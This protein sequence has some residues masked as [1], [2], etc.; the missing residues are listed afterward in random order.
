MVFFATEFITFF[1]ASQLNDVHKVAGVG[2]GV[3]WMNFFG[4][5]SY[6]GFNGAIDQLISNEFGKG[7]YK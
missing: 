1:I 6:F 7:D 2:I 5:I 4:L 3:T